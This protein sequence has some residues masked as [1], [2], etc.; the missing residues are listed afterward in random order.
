MDKLCL[1]FSRG[2]G[3]P[4]MRK[5]KRKAMNQIL[6]PRFKDENKCPMSDMAT[7]I[8]F[9]ILRGGMEN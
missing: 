9:E 8:S 2:G 4:S 1:T 6:R 3:Y 7:A 5:F